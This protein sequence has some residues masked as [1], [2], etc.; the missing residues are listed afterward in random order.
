[1]EFYFIYGFVLFIT[2]LTILLGYYYLKSSLQESSD[3]NDDDENWANKIFIEYHAF[4]KLF[5]KR[6]GTK[7]LKSWYSITLLVWGILM[8]IFMIFMVI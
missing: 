6:K 8:L 1:M 5:G 3:N 4:N 7:K 2:L